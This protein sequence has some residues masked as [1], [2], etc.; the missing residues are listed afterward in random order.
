MYMCVWN[1][2][3]CVFVCVYSFKVY[4]HTLRE[5]YGQD[6]SYLIKH[7]VPRIFHTGS[8]LAA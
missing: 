1:L 6:I 3:V 5:D 2:C 7:V 4:M 8:H